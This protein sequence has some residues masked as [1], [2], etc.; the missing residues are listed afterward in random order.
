MTPFRCADCGGRVRMGPPAPGTMRVYGHG[1]EVPYPAG[2][3]IPRCELCGETWMGPEDSAR[4]DAAIAAALERGVGMRAALL[5]EWAAAPRPEGVN[6]AIAAL[7]DDDPL[8]HARFFLSGHNRLG[9]ARPI[10]CLARGEVA[11]VLQA[12]RN[13]REH[14]AQ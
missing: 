1:V 11:A 9:G 4:V 3:D 13:Y 2:V 12:A 6:E 5:A 7:K 10:D 14:G 8:I